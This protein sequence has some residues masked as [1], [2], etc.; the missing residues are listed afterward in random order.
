MWGGLF[1]VYDC[2][3]LGLR[4][5]DSPVNAIMAGFMTGGTLAIRSGFQLAWRNAIAGG[6]I[7]SII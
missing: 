3:F 7:L 6:I 5:I 1:A 2:T 4:Q